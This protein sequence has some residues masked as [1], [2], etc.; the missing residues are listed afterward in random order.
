[1]IVYLIKTVAKDD[2]VST[3]DCGQ[4]AGGMGGTPGPRRQQRQA[5][6]GAER[7]ADEQSFCFY[8]EQL[9]VTGGSGSGGMGE[10]VEA[11]IKY[12]RSKPRLPSC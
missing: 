2:S 12:L 9:M 1:M 4:R 5:R 8:S 6:S 10:G 3:Q 7:R 11:V